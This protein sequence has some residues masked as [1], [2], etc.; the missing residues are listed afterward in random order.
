MVRKFTIGKRIVDES[1]PPLIVAE[2][3]INHSGNVDKA[4][5]MID[6][7]KKVY[8]KIEGATGRPDLVDQFTG[9][10]NDLATAISSSNAILGARRR[11]SR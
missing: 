7:A 8:N 6:D 11:Y 2:V 1:T 3:G 5:Q 4:I 10:F 9:N